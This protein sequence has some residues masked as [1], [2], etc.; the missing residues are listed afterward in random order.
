MTRYIVSLGSSLFLNKL[1]LFL[2][3]IL[4]RHSRSTQYRPGYRS[5]RGAAR[6]ATSLRFSTTPACVVSVWAR[7]LSQP[8]P[9]CPVFKPGGIR[10]HFCAVGAKYQY[11]QGDLAGNDWLALRSTTKLNQVDSSSSLCPMLFLHHSTLSSTLYPRT[12][13]SS[14]GLKSYP[15]ETFLHSTSR[16]IQTHLLK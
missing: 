16:T 10:Y 2:I 4:I 15:T 6:V 1:F 8:C 12:S 7:R 14:A 5:L 13:T 3:L 9:I 11:Y